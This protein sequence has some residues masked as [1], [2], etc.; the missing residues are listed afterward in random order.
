MTES[1]DQIRK[2]MCLKLKQSEFLEDFPSSTLQSTL[3]CTSKVIQLDF[4]LNGGHVSFQDN[5]KN[6]LRVNKEARN[7]ASKDMPLE[8][9]HGNPANKTID[10]CF[11]FKKLR[12]QS[13]S[14]DDGMKKCGDQPKSSAVHEKRKETSCQ[15]GHPLEDSDCPQWNPI[16]KLYFPTNF[17]NTDMKLLL[18]NAKSKQGLKEIMK[19]ILQKALQPNEDSDN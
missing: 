19:I 10:E 13:D 16:R 4:N 7:N 6:V 5:F 14:I 2:D 11:K 17:R 8:A 18:F 3:L 1:K 9:H 15:C 12:F